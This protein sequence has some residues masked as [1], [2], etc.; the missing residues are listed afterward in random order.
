MTF[1]L[2]LIGYPIQHSLSP[3][4]HQ[5]FLTKANLEGTYSIMEISSDDSFEAELDNLKQKG[6][7]GFNVTLPF[8]KRIIPFLDGMDHH[9]E[10][11]GAVNTV[12]V[13]N[14]KWIGYNTDGLGYFTALKNKYPELC[15][16]PDIP[17]LIIGAGGAARGIYYSLITNGFSHVDIANRTRDN[18]KSIADLN[19]TSGS[20][21]VLNLSEAEDCIRHY[22]LIIQTSS[23][24]MKPNEERVIVSAEGVKPSSVV[25]DI[26]YQPIETTFLKQAKQAGAHIH[27]G[28]SMLL[29]QAQAAFQ[30]WT[31][32]L[33]AVGEMDQQLQTILEGR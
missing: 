8:K 20:S 11:I 27:Y 13:Q 2:G 31:N 5:G 3:W 25:S 26:I 15:A 16:D 18:A 33:V 7:S 23:I 30:L 29:Y 12:V 24:G 10:S 32:K 17:I 4:I 21:A 19:N 22:D 9:A 6:L 1:Q 28:H 14:G